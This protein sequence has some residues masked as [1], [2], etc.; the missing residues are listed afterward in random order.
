MMSASKSQPSVIEN[1]T[2]PNPLVGIVQSPRTLA[3]RG[4]YIKSPRLLATRDSD[5]KSPRLLT[6]RDIGLKFPTARSPSP[7]KKK[8]KARYGTSIVVEFNPGK[9]FNNVVA[10]PARA[11]LRLN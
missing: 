11:Y 7:L 4:N 5:L 6:S 10:Q 3:Y 1:A 9:F 8:P 2:L